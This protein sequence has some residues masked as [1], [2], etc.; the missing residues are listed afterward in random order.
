[1]ET[2]RVFENYPVRILVLSN[3][4]S[5]IIYSS[6]FYIMLQT[7]LIIAGAYLLFILLLEYRLIS[8]HCT[9]CYY[10]GK[11][12]GFGRGRISSLFFKKGDSK[13]FCNN[14]TWKDMIPD[15]LITLIPLVTGIVLMIVKFDFLVLTAV[16]I[17][18]IM[19]TSGNGYIRGKLTCK[20]CV[21]RELGC[22]AEKLFKKDDRPV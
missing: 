19:A 2:A 3:F 21:Q 7:G 1:M 6:G 10:W 17:L 14:F 11:T 18:L 5:L 8:R 13:V 20:F 4:V 9:G 12:C 22:P 15:L 16:F